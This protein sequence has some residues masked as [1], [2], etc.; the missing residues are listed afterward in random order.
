MKEHKEDEFTTIKISKKLKDRL[1]NIK[2]SEHETYEEII[3]KM[4]DLMNNMK[5][6]PQ[7]A[8]RKLKM[9]DEQIKNF[10]EKK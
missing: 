7:K 6:S 2:I 9:L 1:S 3:T 8:M 5:T 4:F 10:K